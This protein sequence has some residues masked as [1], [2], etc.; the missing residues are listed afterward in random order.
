ML[1]PQVY[2]SIFVSIT[3]LSSFV[4]KTVAPDNL[5]NQTGAV[6]RCLF[7]NIHRFQQGGASK[8]DLP[9]GVGVTTSS[10]CNS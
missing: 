9:P 4:N 2:P 3:S 5:H 1:T 10:M 7:F 6:A 8:I